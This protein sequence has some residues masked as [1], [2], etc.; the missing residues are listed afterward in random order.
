[1][2]IWIVAIALLI[3]G[4][5]AFIPPARAPSRLAAPE[6]ASVEDALDRY[7]E[8]VRTMNYKGIASLF[9]ESG[10]I[11]N[12]G[13][14]PVQGPKAIL[15][16]MESFSAYRVRQ[17]QVVADATTADGDHARQTGRYRQRVTL[18]GGGTVEVAGRFVA[19]WRCVNGGDWKIQRMATQPDA[20]ALAPAAAVVQEARRNQGDARAALK[21][22]DR[23]TAESLLRRAVAL[24]PMHPGLK[25]ELA[26][27][28]AGNG[29]ADTAARQ[30]K[31]AAGLGYAFRISSN[32]AF[33]TLMS[34][35]DVVH[36]EAHIA[37]SLAP[38]GR[39]QIVAGDLPHGIIAEGLAG[40]T[41]TTW[42]SSVAQGRV[43]RLN[44]D[45]RA[46][47]F[48][49]GRLYGAF[50]MKVDR[51]RNALWLA[52]S[53]TNE[54]AASR[55]TNKVGKAGVARLNLQSGMVEALYEPPADSAP[56]MI[57]DVALAPNGDV[58]ATDSQSPIIYRVDVETKS[59][60]TWLTTP[61]FSSLQGMAF[62]A[63]GRHAFVAD[64]A[65]GIAQIDMATKDVHWLDAPHDAMLL[66]IDGLYRRGCD[67]IATQNGMEPQ[68]VLRLRLAT[69]GKSVRAVDVVAAN[70]PGLSDIT[71]GT[72]INDDTL[73]LIARS[74]WHA[75]K[76][77]GT[78]PD[79]LEPTVLMDI[80][81]PPADCGLAGR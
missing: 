1:L 25:V 34:H 44:T 39:G 46:L 43:Y 79:Q 48:S 26:G 64:Y 13:A 80:H 28:L 9:S 68:R 69:D 29:H 3:S 31:T 42:I 32:P 76:P 61:E 59:L 10:E 36:A 70:L 18:P 52:T 60:S 81:L 73:R 20:T 49:S 57:G 17:Y 71:L 54:H 66:G 12:P 55:A 77:D 72:L 75:V 47:P 45:G 58:F 8:Y 37:S 7:A 33:G 11:I 16:F 38:V 65:I 41:H 40:D 50:G 5:T 15:A 2:R 35:P 23:L 6:T 78:L 19:D 51:A 4:C 21:L 62:S 27:V 63:D 24:R 67:L 30:L 22:E 53:Q 14:Y 56:R 74:D